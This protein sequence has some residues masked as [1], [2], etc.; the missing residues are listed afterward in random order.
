[1]QSARRSA[2]RPVRR[3]KLPKAFD[4]EVFLAKPGLGRTIRHYTPK[5]AIFS[6]GDR[7]DTIYYIQEGRVRLSV[8]SKQGKEATI[9]LLHPGDFLGEGCIAAGQPL[10]LSTATA[11][12]NCTV[13]R[14]ERGA[15]LRTLHEEHGFSDM[16]VS[17]IVGRHNQTQADLVRQALAEEWTQEAF[18]SALDAQAARTRPDHG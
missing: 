9:T 18:E 10:R 16:F 3:L 1:M 13:L 2:K 11:M 8:L 15:M 5:Q 4:A 14:I 7:A 17:Y 12:T 6:Q